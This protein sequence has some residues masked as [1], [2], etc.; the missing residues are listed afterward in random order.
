MYIHMDVSQYKKV[1]EKLLASD[2][3]E[4][5]K[6]NRVHNSKIFTYVRMHID[7]Y[8]HTY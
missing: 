3:C 4:G 7:M 6:S 8:M 5:Y 2:M 1:Y